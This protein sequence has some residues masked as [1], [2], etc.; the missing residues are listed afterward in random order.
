MF[1]LPAA[2]DPGCS[3][4]WAYFYGYRIASN[5][6]EPHPREPE[7]ALSAPADFA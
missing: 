7:T 5:P 6:Y 3:P 2:L 1:H 4:G